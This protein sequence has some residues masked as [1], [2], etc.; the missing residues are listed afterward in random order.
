[1]PRQQGRGREH[2]VWLFSVAKRAPQMPLEGYSQRGLTHDGCGL[3][4][5]S[6]GVTLKKQ[7]DGVGGK[8]HSHLYRKSLIYKHFNNRQAPQDTSKN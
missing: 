5:N 8:G 1:M 3:A 7:R 2:Y 4:L 6:Q